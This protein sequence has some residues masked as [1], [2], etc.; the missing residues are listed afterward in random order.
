MTL[1]IALRSTRSAARDGKHAAFTQ[2][3]IEQQRP[4][5][6]PDLDRDVEPVNDVNGGCGELRVRV[7]PRIRVCEFERNLAVP[8]PEIFDIAEAND[9]HRAQHPPAPGDQI[10]E[11]RVCVGFEPPLV[12]EQRQDAIGETSARLNARVARTHIR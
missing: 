2:A 4:V 7:H 5:G 10:D 11:L 12:S 6:A 9:L 3:A 1:A 8:V